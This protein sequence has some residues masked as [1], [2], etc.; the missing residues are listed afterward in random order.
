MR[1]VVMAVMVH[2]K[3]HCNYEANGD[4]RDVSTQRNLLRGEGSKN[5]LLESR[6]PPL[7]LERFTGFVCKEIVIA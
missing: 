1:V 5:Q 6:A 3:A 7:S 4:P 2:A